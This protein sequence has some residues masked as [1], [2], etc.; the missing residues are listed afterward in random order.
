MA[1]HDFKTDPAK[2]EPCTACWWSGTL[3]LTLW[4]AVRPAFHFN[5][6]EHCAAIIKSFIYTVQQCQWSLS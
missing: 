6:A 2:F 3:A 1:Y 5:A 4:H